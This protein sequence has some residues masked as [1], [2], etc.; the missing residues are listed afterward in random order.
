MNKIFFEKKNIL[1]TGGYGFIGGAVIRELLTET[2]SNIFN[3]DKLGYASDSISIDK[4]LYSNPSLKSRYKFIKL[5]LA[6]FEKTKETINFIKPDLVIHLAAESHVDRSI[7]NPDIF[8]QSNIIGTYN[9]IQSIKLYWDRLQQ[10][11]KEKFKFHHISTDEVYGSLG[12]TGK[13]NESSNFDPRSPYSATKAAS[14]HLIMS[15][16]HTYGIPVVITNCSNNFGPWQ[17]PEKLIPNTILKALNKENIPIYGNGKNIRD[18]LYVEDHV[19]AILTV[20]SKGRIGKKY[21]IGGQNE[22]TN[23]QIVFNI[24]KFLD[25]E[26]P[27]TAP[28]NRLIKYVTDRP[29]HDKR[30]AIDSSFITNE[31]DWTPKY[32]FKDALIKTIKW[33]IK[34]IEWCKKVI[35]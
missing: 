2:N 4:I 3:I 31:L 17:Y 1:I 22:M 5:D 30:Y 13:F 34:N 21:C 26:L 8:I 27:H 18:W 33:Y 15:W 24:C 28:N 14:D 19:N 16:F 23:N 20:A 11:R 29:G 32:S 10:E 12:E 9:L 6:N 35:S 25:E 7:N